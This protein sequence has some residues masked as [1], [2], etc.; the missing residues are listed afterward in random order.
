MDHERR[1]L[2]LLVPA[3]WLDLHRSDGVELQRA[4]VVRWIA[5]GEQCLARTQPS[6]PRAARSMAALAVAIS[7][8]MER[9]QPVAALDARVAQL[10]PTLFPLAVVPGMAAVPDG[11]ALTAHLPSPFHADGADRAAPRESLETHGS[12]AADGWQP[13]PHLF[14][15]GEEPDWGHVQPQVLPHASTCRAQAPP[16]WSSMAFASIRA[17]FL[18]AQPTTAGQRLSAWRWNLAARSGGVIGYWFRVGRILLGSAHIPATRL[19]RA[20][21]ILGI[22]LHDACIACWESK[23]H[24]RLLRPIQWMQRDMPHW[25]PVITTPAHPAYPSAHA[26]LAGAA[27]AVLGALMPAAR[28]DLRWVAGQI[29]SARVAAGVHWPIDG[30]A[31]L[32]MGQQVAARVLAHT[33]VARRLEAR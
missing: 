23:Y 31:G 16:A 26:V 1:A 8:S 19:A 22:A 9:G 5:A 33:H 17:A 20:L 11:I 27:S 3:M 14:A 28:R 10:L 32:A 24:Y 7:D 29:A 12:S 13:T 18:Q 25:W 21:A 2:S 6:P 15:A 30:T 4:A